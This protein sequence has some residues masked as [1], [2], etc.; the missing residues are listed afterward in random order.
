[1]NALKDCTNSK[2]LE[3]LVGDV[4]TAYRIENYISNYNGI[5]DKTDLMK[6]KGVGETTAN[7]VLACL[8]LTTRY[9]VGTKTESVNKPEDIALKLAWMRYE[10]QEHVV[11]ITLDSSNQVIKIHEIGKGLVNQ[12]S[13]APREVYRHAVEDNAVSVMIAHNHPSGRLEP[14]PEDYGITRVL[15]AAGKIL[16]IPCI[17]HLVI[18]RRGFTSICR[19]NPE[20]FESYME[21]KN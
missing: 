2:L 9:I 17:D 10:E 20:I 11:V 15:C 3:M 19:E 21:S 6:I 12:V 5:P 1:M 8:E 4:E 13:I 7:R 18:S 14:S 16:Q